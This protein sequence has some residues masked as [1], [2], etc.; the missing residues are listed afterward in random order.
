MPVDLLGDVPANRGLSDL[1]YHLLDEPFG[2]LF[3]WQLRALHAHQEGVDDVL[4]VV[5]QLPDIGSPD[6]DELTEL[7]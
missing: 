3:A 2:A 7:L 1:L 5:G 4:R 6:L